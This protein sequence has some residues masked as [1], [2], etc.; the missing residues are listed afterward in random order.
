[1]SGLGGCSEVLQLPSRG[2]KW[3]EQGIRGGG[4]A[5]RRGP[6]MSGGG[7]MLSAGVV[8]S[9]TRQFGRPVDQQ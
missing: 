5:G 8:W 2:G 4:A 1:M 3:G 7:G 9:V 6:A